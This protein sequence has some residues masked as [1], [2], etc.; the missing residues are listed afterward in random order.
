MYLSNE[1]A[2]KAIVQAGHRLY[3]RGYVAAND[4][5]IAARMADGTVW[6]TPTGISKGSLTEDMLVHLTLDGEILEGTY[7]VSSEIRLH[8]AIFREDP[9]L[10]GV[11]HAHS[12]W[13]TAWAGYGEPFDKAACLDEALSMGVVPCAP[14]ATTGSKA[15]A[16]GAVPYVKG[17]TALFLEH[18]G[19][20][21]W[22]KDV[23][24]ALFRT[25]LLEHSLQIYAHQL[26]FGRVRLLSQA[27]LDD[28]ELV[29]QKYGIVNPRATGRD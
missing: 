17:H 24:Q 1:A 16:E 13:A 23:E 3:Q 28:V 2:K 14:Y 5:N 12:P 26:A 4:G 9:S 15:L 10:A 19:A 22:G 18:H 27:Q 11:V 21:T 6:A 20:V 25:E 7:A 8:L 29:K